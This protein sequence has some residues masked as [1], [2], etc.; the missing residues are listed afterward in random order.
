MAT[1]T[2]RKKHATRTQRA[3][4]GVRTLAVD[5]GGSGVKV[6]V[7]DERGEPLGER[8]RE[9]T[10]RPAT[11]AA[12]VGTIAKLAARAGSFDRV[13]VGF[14]GVMRS[15]VVGTAV[16]LDGE[17]TGFELGKVLEKRLG[18][19][20]RVANDATIQGLGAI[21][22]K[23]IELVLTLGTGMGSAVYVNGAAIPNL[24]MGLHPF[25]KGKTYEDL[26][27]DAARRKHKKKWN[28]T[29]R[30]AI[31]QLDRLFNYD[32]L[33]IGGGNA[34]RIEGP[35]PERASIVSNHAGL[36]GGIALWR[37]EVDFG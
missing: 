26:L 8:L 1:T 4:G 36:T 13:S 7:L 29:L 33:F 22:G 25:R 20:V 10:P 27:G 16:N 30:K 5:I 19:P 21:T 35:L 14:P 37:P 11:P 9:P 15:G 12:V 23:G 2:V 6:M 17:W 3:G 28:K 32:R 31:D 24:E 34:S 18:K